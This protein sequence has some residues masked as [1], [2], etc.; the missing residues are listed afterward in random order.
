MKDAIA[1]IL[2]DYAEKIRGLEP[3]DD[4]SIEKLILNYWD[5]C[6][7][8]TVRAFKKHGIKPTDLMFLLMGAVY[9]AAPGTLPDKDNAVMQMALRCRLTDDAAQ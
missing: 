5:T 1:D 9:E 8:Q 2:A 3:F 6:T 4:H 7:V